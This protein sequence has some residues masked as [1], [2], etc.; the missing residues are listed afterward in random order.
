MGKASMAGAIGTG[1][2]PVPPESRAMDRPP[3]EEEK[4]ALRPDDGA[5]G[6]AFLPDAS[7]RPRLTSNLIL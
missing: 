3:A 5:N 1:G 2:T 6:P 4:R 7:C